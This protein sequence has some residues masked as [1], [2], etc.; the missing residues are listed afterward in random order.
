M[1]LWVKGSTDRGERPLIQKPCC[2]DVRKN[3]ILYWNLSTVAIFS[4][5]QYSTTKFRADHD[6]PLWELVQKPGM[7]ALYHTDGLQIYITYVHCQQHKIKTKSLCK[8]KVK[9]MSPAHNSLCLTTLKKLT[10][11]QIL[12]FSFLLYI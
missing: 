8:K 9:F 7:P 12:H 6:L 10:T 3:E 5:C 11:F 1:E 2:P 4:V